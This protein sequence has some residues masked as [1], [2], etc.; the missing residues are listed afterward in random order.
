[1]PAVSTRAGR[2][3]KQ[4]TGYA[5]FIPAPLPPDPPVALDGTLQSLLSRADQAVGRLDGVIQTVP[6]P[7]F[8]VYMYVRREAVL[9]S[10]I[11]GTQSTL[12]DLLAASSNPN[13]P[14]AGCPRRRTR[15]ST[16]CGR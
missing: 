7:D 9:S 16:T 1:M 14:G 4:R 2:Y 6:N 15:S 10:Q 8:F 13:P 5:A 11:E 3:V 12:E